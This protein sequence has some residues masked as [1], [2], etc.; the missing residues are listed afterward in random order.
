[1]EDSILGMWQDVQFFVLTDKPR[2]G[3]RRLF[4]RVAD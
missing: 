4:L 3:N 1:M 2:L